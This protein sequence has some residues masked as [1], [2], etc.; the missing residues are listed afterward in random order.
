[1]DVGERQSDDR[2]R[3]KRFVE[4]LTS[5]Q[6]DLY[7][8]I[9]TLLLGDSA[10]SDVLQDT[11]LDL[12][13]E[14]DKF[15]FDRPFLAWAFGFAFQ[16]VLAFRKTRC[17]SRLVFSD[18]AVRMI[19]DAYVTDGDADA[20]LVALRT[21]LDKLTPPHGQLIRDRYLAKL[22]VK[23][24]AARSGRTANQISAQLYRIRKVLAA[25]VDQTLVAEAR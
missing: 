2:S 1:V 9:N 23:T 14:L 5:H 21:C 8:Y 15:D 13:S 17:R 18:E 11:N 7:A 24:L 6:R 16:R 20:R 19:S 25:C 4:L 10:A 22:S 3:A 12:W